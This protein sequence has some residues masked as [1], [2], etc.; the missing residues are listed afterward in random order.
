MRTWRSARR[1]SGSTRGYRGRRARLQAP[2][3]TRGHG[4]PRVVVPAS[5]LAGATTPPRGRGA[6]HRG[7]RAQRC[8]VRADVR[9]PLGAR[10]GLVPGRCGDERGLLRDPDASAVVAAGGRSGLPSHAPRLL[11]RREDLQDGPRLRGAV[12]L[13]GRPVP[14]LAVA[15]APDRRRADGRIEP[16]GDRELRSWRSAHPVVHALHQSRRQQ[17]ARRSRGGRRRRLSPDRRDGGRCRHRGRLL[18]RIRPR[19]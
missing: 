15:G 14:R 8:L 4:H 5:G 18:L 13:L 12:R 16:A 17:P 1:I 9:R 11:R 19:G 6:P 10:A 2:A 7:L 3:G